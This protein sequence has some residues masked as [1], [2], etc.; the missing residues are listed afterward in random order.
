MSLITEATVSK[1]ELEYEQIGLRGYAVRKF[2]PERTR[3]LI[4]SLPLRIA[5]EGESEY[6]LMNLAVLIMGILKTGKIK[7]LIPYEYSRVIPE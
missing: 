3:V 7:L 4:S 5:L 6:P 1:R 2:N